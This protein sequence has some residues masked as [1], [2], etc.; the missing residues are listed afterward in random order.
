MD[1]KGFPHCCWP[2]CL[3]L[4]S[5]LPSLTL[6]VMPAPLLYDDVSDR[7]LPHHFCAHRWDA[8]SFSRISK[9][10]GNNDAC[11]VSIHDG[12]NY[13]TME[14]EGRRIFLRGRNFAANRASPIHP[15]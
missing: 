5:C 3:P 6:S 7:T 10:T 13:H 9:E 8:R 14:E 11:D 12:G 2:T 4:S 15:V 1:P